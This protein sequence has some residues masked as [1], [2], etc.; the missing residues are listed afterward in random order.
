[1]EG[2][3]LCIEARQFVCCRLFAKVFSVVKPVAAEEKR[4]GREVFSGMTSKELR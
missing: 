4:G 1:L 3:I 2:F